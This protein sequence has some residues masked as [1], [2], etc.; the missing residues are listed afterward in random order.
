MGN[1]IEFLENRLPKI[2]KLYHCGTGFIKIEKGICYYYVK[3]Y[4]RDAEMHCIKRFKLLSSAR[5]YLHMKVLTNF[6]MNKGE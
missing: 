1:E 4:D 3:I 6:T 5:D 2:D